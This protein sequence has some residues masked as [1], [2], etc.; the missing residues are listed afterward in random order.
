MPSSEVKHEVRFLEELSNL[1][2]KGDLPPFRYRFDRSSSPLSP[3]QLYSCYVFIF[4]FKVYLVSL[5]KLLS[6]V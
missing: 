5:N 3:A 6:Q 4:L 1:H 2:R